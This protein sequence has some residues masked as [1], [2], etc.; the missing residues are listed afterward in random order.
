MTSL[1][2]FCQ[3]R[4]SSPS[5]ARKGFRSEPPNPRA[6][7]LLSTKLGSRAFMTKVGVPVMPGVLEPLNNA[8][9]A[10]KQADGI[11]YPV[12]LK[13]SGGSRGRGMRVVN[14]D[15]EMEDAFTSA[16]NATAKAF[17][18]S[19]IYMEKAFLRGRHIEFQVVGDSRGDPPVRPNRTVSVQRRSPRRF[20][21]TLVS[22]PST[23]EARER[24]QRSRQRGGQEGRVHLAG[25][26][27]ISQ[28]V[29][30]ICTSCIK[31]PYPGG[32]SNH[33]AW[34]WWRCNS[35]SPPTRT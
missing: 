35:P 19:T 2:D 16:R 11:G 23:E 17:N 8:E 13:A 21:R 1:C 27:L 22:V 12:M 24:H 9:D 34:I 25:R 32:A 10:K 15:E 18:S 4:P 26:V 29:T 31:L 33:L 7:K 20:W 14:T 3:R 5:A 6:M 30:G 28:S